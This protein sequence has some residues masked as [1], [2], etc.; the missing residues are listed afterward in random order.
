MHPNPTDTSPNLGAVF[1][2]LAHPT[3]RA[4]VAR[5]AE[6]PATAGELAAPFAMSLPAVSKHL[7]VLERAGLMRREVVGRVH[8]CHA[9]LEPMKAAEVWIRQRNAFW[10]TKLAALGDYLDGET[11]PGKT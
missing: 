4:M 7:K 11:E 5:L 9:T 10:D 3:R 2:A 8:H 6:G 1:A